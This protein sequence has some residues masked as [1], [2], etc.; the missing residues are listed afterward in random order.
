VS[1]IKVFISYCTAN[2]ER[3]G[4]ISEFAETLREMFRN[5]EDGGVDAHVYHSGHNIVPGDDWREGLEAELDGCDIFMPMCS[6]EYFRSDWCGREWAYFR[7]RVRASTPFNRPLPA[8]IFPVIWKRLDQMPSVLE[9]IQTA[10]FTPA[11]YPQKSLRQLYL[12]PGR[13]YSGAVNQLA[14]EIVHKKNA[15]SNELPS[16]LGRSLGQIESAFD[17]AYS[18]LPRRPCAVVLGV[19]NLAELGTLSAA[20]PCVTHAYSADRSRWA[21]FSSPP[22]VPA[23]SAPTA[24][25]AAALPAATEAGNGAEPAAHPTDP[26]AGATTQSAEPTPPG[27]VSNGL[28]WAD[29]EQRFPVLRAYWE[30]RRRNFI[31]DDPMIELLDPLRRSRSK[32]LKDDHTPALFLVDGWA[33][34]AKAAQDWFEATFTRCDERRLLLHATPGAPPAGNGTPIHAFAANETN[35]KPPTYLYLDNSNINDIVESL[36]EGLTQLW[37]YEHRDP[38]DTQAINPGCAPADGDGDD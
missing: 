27:A 32:R 9:H 2:E 12:T 13:A 29:A 33:L 31:P 21:P 36:E 15:F 34:G 6:P 10:T 3:E 23:A 25:P 8:L 30:M 18:T 4:Y 5:G 24:P 1:K 38:D 35:N 26:A 16:P 11:G 22:P 7:E 20:E 19:P 14:T 17:T 37:E 28:T